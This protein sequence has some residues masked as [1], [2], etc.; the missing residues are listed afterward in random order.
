[1]KQLI[2]FVRDPGAY[3]AIF[4][5]FVALS[6][7][8]N[9][10]CK[11]FCFG[12]AASMNTAFSASEYDVEK[13]LREN[14][15]SIDALICGTGFNI[16]WELSMMEKCKKYGILTVA[17]LDYWN[18]YKKRFFYDGRVVWPDI[19]IVMDSIAKREAIEE[20]VPA[21]I[22][23]VLGHPGI[24]SVLKK[25]KIIHNSTQV[26][27]VLLLGQPI[28]KDMGFGYDERDFFE[29]CVSILELSNKDFRIKF[30]PRDEKG[31]RIR[32]GF[33]NIEGGLLDIAV[34]FDMV[35]GMTTIALL[36]TA[37]I[38]LNSISYQPGLSGKDV[39]IS[40]KLGLSKLIT[41]KDELLVFLLNPMFPHRKM[42]ANLLWMD[43][44]STR[45]FVNFMKEL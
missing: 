30:H 13:W 6:I 21:H 10:D 29:D 4:P 23:R 32:Y 17:V 22:I 7:E 19:Y 12:T 1:M 31:I 27:R 14:I 37:L 33:Y 34:Q 16:E 15:Q 36:H 2:F 41:S 35:I 44:E 9:V 38:G 24:D 28:S 39:A 45:R 11:L 25:K 20:G 18:N 26:S 42:P 40:N 5:L 8:I 3:S 43:G